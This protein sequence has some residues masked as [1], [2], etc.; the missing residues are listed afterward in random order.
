MD[1]GGFTKL[2]IEGQNATACLDRLLCG[3]LP[4]IGRLRLTWALDHH[5][6]IVSEFTVTRLAQNVFYLVS[7]ASGHD[8]DLAWIENAFPAGGNVR[9]TD[10]SGAWGTLVIAGPESRDLLSRVTDAPLGNGEFPWLSAK[11]IEIGFV[12]IS[13]CA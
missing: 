7:A 2:Q 1:M 3:R 4:G 10:L 9:V 13:R 12:P 11:E 5:A 6:H 8:H